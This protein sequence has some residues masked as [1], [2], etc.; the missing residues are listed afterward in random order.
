MY[1]GFVVSVRRHFL[2]IPISDCHHAYRDN[3]LWQAEEFGYRFC[4]LL[5]RIQ[6]APDC[7]KAYTMGGR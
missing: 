5:F 2:L 6:L 3:C 4:Q 1:L 7:A